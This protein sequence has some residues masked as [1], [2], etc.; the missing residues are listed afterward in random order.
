MLP[1]VWTSAKTPPPSSTYV[2]ASTCASLSHVLF[3]W[4]P[5]TTYW[6]NESPFKSLVC[7]RTR[8]QLTATLAQGRRHYNEQVCGRETGEKQPCAL[9]R[10]EELET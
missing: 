10:E 3:V 5:V 1:G 9:G 2:F 6:K 4:V 8:A 7:Q